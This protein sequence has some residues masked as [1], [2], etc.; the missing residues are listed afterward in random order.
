VQYPQP[1]LIQQNT[2]EAN[3]LFEGFSEGIR[4]IGN[5]GQVSCSINEHDG[6]I[7][8]SL[9]FE[10]QTGHNFVICLPPSS[11]LA[12]LSLRGVYRISTANNL[13]S[14]IPQTCGQIIHS[15]DG[16]INLL[17]GAGFSEMVHICF[18]ARYISRMQKRFL[19]LR[20]FLFSSEEGRD[21]SLFPFPRILPEKVLTLAK[22]RS[23]KELTDVLWTCLLEELGLSAAEF[24]ALREGAGYYD[25]KFYHAVLL[26]L[27]N[28]DQRMTISQL[29]RKVHLNEFRLKR[30]F[31][32]KFSMSLHAFQEKI[33]IEKAKA[34]VQE[35]GKPLS[36]IASELGY[37]SLSHFSAAFKKRTGV[38]PG[39]Y[40]R[41]LFQQAGNTDEVHRG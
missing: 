9:R 29:A 36:R 27:V 20:E 21:A 30:G 3:L 16:K 31:K 1:Y 35:N 37:Y 38:R 10:L 17:V 15:A 28:S 40:R 32:Q 34:W 2:E 41:Q 39:V 24:A 6:I 4:R 18:P 8:L 7:F 11:L 12:I 33:R 13:Q 25:E 19:M 23:V 5:S 22:E 14:L 26:L